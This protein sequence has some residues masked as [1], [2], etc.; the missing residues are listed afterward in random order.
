LA[1]GVGGD[2][3][4]LVFES[5]APNGELVARKVIGI[6]RGP[7]GKKRIHNE[8]GCAP[9]LFGWQAMPQDAD[10]AVITEGQIDAM[11]WHA[12]GFSALSV[13]NGV[14]DPGWVEYEWENLARFDRIYLSFDADEP[15]Q[16]AVKEVARRLGLHRC[17]IVPAVAGHKDANEALM[18]GATFADF[19]K[20]IT[21]AKCWTPPEIRRPSDFAD[22]V[23]A[24]LF[25]PSGRKPGF[26]PETL[27]SKI[28][29]RD[30]ELSIWTGISGHGKSNLLLQ[31]AM[32]AAAYGHKVAIASM[33]MPGH[34]TLIQAVK[35]GSPFGP[36]RLTP[37][38]T[39]HLLERL[40]NRLWIF[41]L[42]GSVQLARLLDLMEY[43]ARRYAVTHFVVDSLMK[44]DVS[45]EDYEA[46]RVTLNSLVSF[47]RQ[48]S[49][50]VHLV[51]H[52]RKQAD[53]NKNPGKMD[54]KG[55]GDIINQGDNI[56]SVWRNKAKEEKA[57]NVQLSDR[58]KMTVP[59]TI[60]YVEK[61]RENGE[62]QSIPLLFNKAR[63]RFVPTETDFTI[64]KLLPDE[65]TP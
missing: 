64:P 15:G 17:W 62:E 1:F 44:L 25:D 48:N 9:S 23:I 18:A 26:W 29:F 34:K 53:E 5:L 11:T 16:K 65:D 59:D 36:E 6:D 40:G 2:S 32:E 52:A 45:S 49:A 24:N 28:G 63:R 56:L 39:R 54:V 43:A 37:D 10:V 35:M 27:H 21:D 14:G 31:V 55:S 3:Q 12:M 46:Q 60:V 47:A 61:D 42:L 51:C 13:P 30:G 50:H 7:D 33:E 4:S 58:E 57:R 22:A 20:A 8:P 38:L 19:S 41:D